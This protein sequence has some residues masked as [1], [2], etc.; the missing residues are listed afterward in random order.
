MLTTGI[1]KDCTFI[2]VYAGTPIRVQGVA[3]GTCACEAPLSVTA[4]GRTNAQREY[5]L[6]NIHT[7]VRTEEIWSESDFAGASKRTNGV[8]ADL[9]T[10]VGVQVTFVNVN[11]SRGC[12]GV[13]CTPAPGRVPGQLYQIVSRITATVIATISI[14]TIL[15]TTTIIRVTFIDIDTLLSVVC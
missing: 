8:D 6:V 3:I 1:S 2:N 15:L 13:V 10:V 14:H 12:H 7:I 5:A 4:N 9:V 11:T